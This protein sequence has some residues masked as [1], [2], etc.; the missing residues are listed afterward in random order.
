[1]KTKFLSVLLLAIGVG[2]IVSS[3]LVLTGC[4]MPEVG[5]EEDDD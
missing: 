2:L 5:G 4:E 1:M 3:P